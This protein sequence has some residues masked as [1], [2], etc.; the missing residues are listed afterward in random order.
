MYYHAAG[1]RSLPNP[2]KTKG[3]VIA[4]VCVF[5]GV[6]PTAQSVN[7][8]GG[9]GAV[10]QKEEESPGHRFVKTGL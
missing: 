3:R 10:K 4:A 6:K 8:R 7:A 2:L 1:R 9:E 5:H